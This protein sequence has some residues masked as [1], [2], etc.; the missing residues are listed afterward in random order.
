[1]QYKT[2]IRLL[3]WLF[4]VL[5]IIVAIWVVGPL[6][7]QLGMERF[8]KHNVNIIYEETDGSKENIN[9]DTN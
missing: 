3:E 2:I 8:Y 5:A 9:N 4:K 6:V 1:M 7:V